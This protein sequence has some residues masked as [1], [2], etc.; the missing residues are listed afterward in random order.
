M[1]EHDDPR[2]AILRLLAEQERLC[3]QMIPV[4]EAKRAALMVSDAEALAPLVREME[5]LAAQAAE[6]ERERVAQAA[7]LTGEADGAEVSFD[8]VAACYGGAGRERLAGL[9]ETL[10]AAL[11][12]LK[13]LNDANAALVRQALSI[14]RQQARLLTGGSPATYSAAGVMAESGHLQTRPAWQA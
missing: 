13:S 11:A 8:A 9:R 6:V 7:R 3:R 5:L 4:A 1:T 2:D 10:R 12:A 14:T